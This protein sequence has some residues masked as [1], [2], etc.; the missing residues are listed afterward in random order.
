MHPFNTFWFAL[1]TSLNMPEDVAKRRWKEIEKCYSSPLRRYHNLNHLQNMAENLVD[2]K[3]DFDPIIGLAIVYHDLVYNTLRKD[4]EER[5]ANVAVVRMREILSDS[6]LDRLHR[7]IVA[8]KTH[9]PGD[10]WLNILLD[11]D[12]SI[13]AKSPQEYKAY[14]RQIR[15]EYLWCPSLLYK[16][17]RIKVLESFLN[18]DFI[19]QTDYFRNKWEKQARE[20]IRLEIESLSS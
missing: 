1:A 18:R 11:I 2:I 14:S 9:S 15:I 4:N 7:Y 17:G 8:T 20:N 3:P 6:D 5:S 16:N 12:L 19:Y 10:E 13:L